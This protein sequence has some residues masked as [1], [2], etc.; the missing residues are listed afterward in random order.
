MKKETE[1]DKAIKKDELVPEVKEG[2][3]DG[4]G[5]N[6]NQG[7]QPPLIIENNENNKK[8]NKKGG[9]QFN[10]FRTSSSRQLVDLIVAYN[11]F[12][13]AG[14]SKKGPSGKKR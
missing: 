1:E 8:E 2:E 5:G 7:T 6:N 11:R 13:F 10:T 9:L 4:K 12:L 3:G 14:D